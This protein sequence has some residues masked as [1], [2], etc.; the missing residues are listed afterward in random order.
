MTARPRLLVDIAAD[1]VC[2]WCYIGLRSFMSAKSALEPDYQV[3]ARFRAYQLGPD[4]PAE[5]VDREAYYEK[6][7]PDPAFRAEA[8]K[9]LIASAAETG[10]PFDPSI[11]KRLPNTLKAHSILRAAHFSGVHEAVALALYGS[12]W[13][14]GVDL[15]D[16]ETLIRLAGEADMPEKAVLETLRSDESREATAAEAAAM[17][18][19][20]VQGV[21][22]FIVNERAGFS[23]ALPP[24]TLAATLRKAA[25]P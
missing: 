7:F 19:A 9:R 16:E 2:P 3:V 10:F 25:G 20:G 8:R 22:T 5:G 17:A 23:G 21:P 11:P 6:R 15:G 18:R 14:N 24:A 13:E 1:F 4:T 12:Y